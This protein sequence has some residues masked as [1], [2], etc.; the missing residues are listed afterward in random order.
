MRLFLR[1]AARSSR[2]AI[3]TSIAVVS[4][5]TAQSTST[6]Q[7]V[8]AEYTAKIRELTP[9]DPKW[10]FTTELVDYLPASTTVPTPL[11]VL[12]Y[13]PG[14]VGKLSHV[15]DINKYFRAVAAAAPSRSRLISLGM[16]DENR[17]ALVLAIA[18]EEAI[19]R[20]DD[21]RAMAA[22][23]ADP[24]GLSSADRAR[25]IREAKPIY[26]VLGPSTRPRRGA[27]RC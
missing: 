4:Q 8:D 9:T 7:P 2:L 17:E 21:Y 6:A 25:L 23:L 12:G 20:L 1:T 16:S 5:A 24:R 10:R 11:K 19:R 13:V 26:W 18:D 15:A 3:L 27:P 14:T 22:R